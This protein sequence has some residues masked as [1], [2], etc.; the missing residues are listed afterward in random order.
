MSAIRLLSVAT[1]VALVALVSGVPTPRL[2]TRVEAPAEVAK[3][4]A[5]AYAPLDE[6]HGS[7]VAINNERNVTITVV[8]TNLDTNERQL[9]TLEGSHY[10]WLDVKRG[11]FSIAELGGERRA[12]SQRRACD[13]R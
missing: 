2:P 12:R 8:V 13:E 7:Q 10:T 6:E 9:H 5:V 1:A 4:A 3:R 11:N